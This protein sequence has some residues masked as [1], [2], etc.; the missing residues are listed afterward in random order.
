[1]RKVTFEESFPVITTEFKAG[2]LAFFRAYASCLE[3]LKSEQ[4]ELVKA[5]N[6]DNN[7]DNYIDML[8]RVT[9]G[10]LEGAPALTRTYINN[11]E[12]MDTLIQEGV[13]TLVQHGFYTDA[14]TN[15]REFI[16]VVQSLI[17]NYKLKNNNE[18]TPSYV[19]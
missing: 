12:L 17:Y 2:V 8:L 13:D 9:E 10:V 18:L 1:M 11:V 14:V 4:S 5:S 15:K 3:N 16:T 7:V 6:V 19:N